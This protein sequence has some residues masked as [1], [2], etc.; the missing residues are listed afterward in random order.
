MAA[1]LLL[2]ALAIWE[3]GSLNTT[4]C[5]SDRN[6]TACALICAR[7]LQGKFQPE[8]NGA[9][10]KDSDYR[11]VGGTKGVYRL[12]RA[13]VG[14]A[15]HMAP[16]NC[17][18]LAC[19]Q[20]FA[21]QREIATSSPEWRP[22]DKVISPKGAD[23]LPNEATLITLIKLSEPFWPNSL[24]SLTQCKRNAHESSRTVQ[25]GSRSVDRS[26]FF[27][28]KSKLSRAIARSKFAS[29]RRRIQRSVATTIMS[30]H[31]SFR[32][33]S[34]RETP[35]NIQ[36]RDPTPDE[37]T[38]QEPDHS[39]DPKISSGTA[40][41]NSKPTIIKKWY[42]VAR[43]REGE[44]VYATW[45][46]TA[47]A[48]VGFKGSLHE[49]FPTR[50]QAEQY[51]RHHRDYHEGMKQKAARLAAHREHEESRTTATRSAHSGRWR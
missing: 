36:Q 11:E 38:S 2:M 31:R 50:A 7:L 46:E 43:G 35:A 3:T 37:P 9:L 18:K 19:L 39:A 51:I 49:A 30:R 33:S 29:Q 5:H 8:W 25:H 4:P 40:T 20:A 24:H 47:K 45:E 27:R 26:K 28:G 6:P 21:T 16:N 17:Q 42:A 12:I 14:S 34:K 13:E 48:V 44:Q 22:V 1:T 15:N 41:P 32:S 23:T 10:A